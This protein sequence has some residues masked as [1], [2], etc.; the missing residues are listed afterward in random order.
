MFPAW[1]KYVYKHDLDR[2]CRFAVNVWGCE[3]SLDK[4]K[5]ALEGIEKTRQFFKS[6]GM[7]VNFEEIGAKKED[8]PL[9]TKKAVAASS[10]GTLG[11]FA[12]LNASDIQKIYEI[13][14]A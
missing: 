9:L 8:I 13:A 4:E 6:I 12:V 7:P 11:G 1:M 3:P 5:L 10:T 2:F 14:A